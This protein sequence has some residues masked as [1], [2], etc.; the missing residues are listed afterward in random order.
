MGGRTSR[1]NIEA[2]WMYPLK[3]A[4]LFLSLICGGVG[5]CF[6]ANMAIVCGP[7]YLKPRK[8]MV[9]CDSQL[10]MFEQ[11]RIA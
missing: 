11:K 7:L 5:V 9:M 6:K 3:V 8:I 1:Y 4:L 2:G 10:W